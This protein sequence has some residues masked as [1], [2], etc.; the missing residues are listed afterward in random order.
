ME[1]TF[2]E[3][4]RRVNDLL[5]RINCWLFHYHSD[6]TTVSGK[7]IKIRLDGIITYHPLT[8]QVWKNTGE[9]QKKKGEGGE[10]MND[11]I[12]IKRS[13]FK[14]APAVHTWHW[15]ALGQN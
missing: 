11:L 3:F 14:N 10:K 13:R 12:E 2:E 4:W 15:T 5:E 1:R 8:I 6:S 9:T 7:Q